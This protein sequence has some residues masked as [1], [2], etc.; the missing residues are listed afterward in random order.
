MKTTQNLTESE[1]RTEL[2]KMGRTESEINSLIK[3]ARENPR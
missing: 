1:V 2:A 3:N